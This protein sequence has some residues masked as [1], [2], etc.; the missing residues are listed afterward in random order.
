M[1]CVESSDT[2]EAEGSYKP[3]PENNNVL[4]GE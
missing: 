2:I 4:G 1:N 3:L